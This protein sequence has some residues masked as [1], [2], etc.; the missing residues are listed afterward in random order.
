MLDDLRAFELSRL[1]VIDRL[2]EA[3]RERLLRSCEH[4]HGYVSDVTARAGRVLVRVGRRL[5]TLGGAAHT[6]PSFE[7]RRRAV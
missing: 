5:E 1:Y 2:A 6:A 4:R 7:M 3:E